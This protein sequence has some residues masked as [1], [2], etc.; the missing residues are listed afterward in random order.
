M[1]SPSCIQSLSILDFSQ[2]QNHKELI[3]ASKVLIASL[4]A[5]ISRFSSDSNLCSGRLLGGVVHPVKF[6]QPKVQRVFNVLYQLLYLQG[7]RNGQCWAEGG[8]S[9]STRPKQSASFIFNRLKSLFKDVNSDFQRSSES[10][11]LQRI[12]ILRLNQI[13]AERFTFY[14]YST[15][16]VSSYFTNIS[17][18]LVST[19]MSNWTCFCWNILDFQAFYTLIQLLVCFSFIFSEFDWKKVSSQLQK[20]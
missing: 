2:S 12:F 10:L 3:K 8:D 5:Q 6:L 19:T 16:R 15:S 7:R 11:S 9:G 1:S 13:A 4:M 20:K 18:Y 14:F 17:S